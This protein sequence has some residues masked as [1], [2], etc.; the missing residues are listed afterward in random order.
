MAWF[1]LLCSLAVGL[2]ALAIGPWSLGHLLPGLPFVPFAVLSIVSGLL[3][4]NLELQNRLVQAREQASYAARLN[5]GRA[6]I[7][8]TLAIVFVVVLH[9]GAAGLISAEVASYGVLALVAAYY[10]RPELKGRFRMPMLRSSLA[11]GV[12]MLP[13]DFVGSMT[14]LVTRG[15]LAGVKS[16]AA[17]GV[18]SVATKFA[19]PLTILAYAFQAAFN[20]I[21]FSMR[22]EETAASMQRLAVTARNVWALA[23]FGSWSRSFGAVVDRVH[24][25]SQLSCGR[26]VAADL[27]REFFGDDHKLAIRHRDL[28]QQADLVGARRRVQ[29]R[30]GGH[31]GFGDYR[32][33]IR[34]GRHRLGH[35]G[36]GF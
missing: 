36:R 31:S 21:Y 10:L 16:V 3:Y 18:L 7:S 15:I 35:V 6:S 13:G 23:I 1:V 33:Q 34:G 4:C 2:A 28:L 25:A 29:C 19:Q 24:D 22:K 9:W 12:A 27:G 32:R 8:I 30:G 11:Y 26:G 5:I 20:P 14:P 17:T